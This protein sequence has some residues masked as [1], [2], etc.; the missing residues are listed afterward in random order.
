MSQIGAIAHPKTS[1]FVGV[2][3]GWYLVSR[4]DVERLASI[5]GTS[6][7]AQRCLD[8]AENYTDPVF[9]RAGEHLVV[10]ASVNVKVN[11]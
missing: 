1:K 6:S 9:F 5:I 10:T 11:G 3:K 7:A 8:E 4:E 2:P